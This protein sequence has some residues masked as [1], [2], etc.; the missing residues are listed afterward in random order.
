MLIPG[1]KG[2][3]LCICTLVLVPRVSIEGRFHLT[4]ILSHAELNII[5][6]TFIWKYSTMVQQLLCTFVV[7]PN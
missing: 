2:L 1:L 6:N 4:I 7:I 3:N 5:L